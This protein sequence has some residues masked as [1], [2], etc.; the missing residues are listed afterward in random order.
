MKTI[1]IKKV[2][3][4]II[5]AV[6]VGVIGGIYIFRTITEQKAEYTL[7]INGKQSDIVSPILSS[8]KMTYSPSRELAEVLELAI[9]WNKKEKAFTAAS[10]AWKKDNTLTE[11]KEIMDR[12]A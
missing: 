10:D 5:C 2:T 11:A 9:E 8:K 3:L 6:L 7:Y 4:I 1:K 12:F